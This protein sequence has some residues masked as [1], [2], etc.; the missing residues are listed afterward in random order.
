ML[1]QYEQVYPAE[2]PNLQYAAL[3]PFNSTLL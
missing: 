1:I 2:I 3:F